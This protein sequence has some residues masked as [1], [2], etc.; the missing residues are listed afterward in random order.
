MSTKRFRYLSALSGIAGVA[1]LGVSFTINPGPPPDATSEQ[2]TAFAQQ[3]YASIFWG[4]WLQAVGPLLI[5]AFAFAIVCLAGATARFAGWMTLCGGIILVIVSLIEVSF[6]FSAF[7]STPPTMGVISLSLIHAVQHLYFII[8]APALF[9]PL[10]AVIVGTAV[11]PR[12]FGYLALALGAAFAILGL[13][14]MFTLTLPTPVTAFAGVQVLW[15]LAAA[16]TLMVRG[17]PPIHLAAC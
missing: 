14:T 10:G 4:A 2:L 12:L 9:L 15:W 3:Y 8:A 6:Y 11:L 17:D 13:A 16:I 7:F 1:M 5:V